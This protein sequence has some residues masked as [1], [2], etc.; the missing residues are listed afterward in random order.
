MGLPGADSR[1]FLAVGIVTAVSVDASGHW[2]TVTVQPSGH[3]ARCRVQ[4]P[5]PGIYLPLAVGAEVAVVWPM[6]AQ[7]VV[8]GPLWSRAEAPPAE[9]I[10]EPAAVW[11]VAPEVRV[12]ATSVSVQA[13]RV[14][15]G[16]RGLGV[17]DGVVHG[18]GIDPFTGL[19]YTALGSVSDVV[20]AEK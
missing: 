20:R 10:A 14:D 15:L 13:D 11:V 4:P 17:S 7:P 12:V 6:G 3:E 9:A 2:A 18:T 5:H 8:I 16:D 19:S 1:F